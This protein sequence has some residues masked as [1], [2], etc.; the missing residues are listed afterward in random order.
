MNTEVF[1][2]Y[3]T[4]QFYPW[5]LQNNI[6][7]PVILFVDGHVSHRSLKLSEFCNEKQIVLVS[8]LPNTTHICQ[9]MDVVVFSAVK[10]KWASTLQSFKI[11]S[12]GEERMSKASFC[13]LLDK[14]LSESLTVSTLTNSFT[15]TALYPF[16]ANGFDFSKLPKQNS[17]KSDDIGDEI[18][19]LETTWSNEDTIHLEE[20]I[21]SLFPHRIAE[22]KNTIG[23]WTGAIESKDLFD[24]WRAANLPIFRQSAVEENETST[25]IDEN[26]NIETENE[27]NFELIDV[28]FNDGNENR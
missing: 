14:C 23:D 21:E 11:Q 19:S 7:P 24:L 13:D 8:L 2:D 26:T 18:C 5:L 3:I 15:K 1:Y 17:E 6:Y 27:D 9:P 12:R 28:I 25:L 16:D 4:K 10:R 22:F 20:M